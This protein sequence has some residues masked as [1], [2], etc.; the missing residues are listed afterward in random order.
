ADI[1]CVPC[2]CGTPPLG[3]EQIAPLLQQLEGWEVEENKKLVKRY[4]FKNFVQAV[5]FVNQITPIAEAEGHHPDLY[6]RWG[7]VRAFVWTHKIDG[8]TE[9]DF[10]LAAKLDRVYSQRG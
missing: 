1:K 9:S 4:K 10:Y 5:D 8:L 6:V 7:E 2:Q 3:T